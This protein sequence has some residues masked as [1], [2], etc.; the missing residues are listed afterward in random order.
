MFTETYLEISGWVN[1]IMTSVG[2]EIRPPPLPVSSSSQTI[3]KHGF[4]YKKAHNK[5]TEKYFVLERTDNGTNLIYFDGIGDFKRNKNLPKRV[6]PL[7]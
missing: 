4:L 5:W 1:A 7:W 2:Q 6:I 3:I